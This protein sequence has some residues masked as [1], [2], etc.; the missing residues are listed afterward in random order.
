MRAN[1]FLRTHYK[2]PSLSFHIRVFILINMK[3]LFSVHAERERERTHFRSLLLEISNIYL[4]PE[5][6]FLC[7]EIQYSFNKINLTD[8]LFPSYQRNVK[9]EKSLHEKIIYTKIFSPSICH[10]SF[11]PT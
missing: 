5:C 2:A 7:N 6:T 1:L 8:S 3:R 10:I 11:S 9:I 4:K